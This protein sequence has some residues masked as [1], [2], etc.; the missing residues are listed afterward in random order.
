MINKYRKDFPLLKAID[1]KKSK[2]N[3]ALV[4]LDT[5]ATAQRPY[6]VLEAMEH[7]YST[8]NANPLRGLYSL[9]ERA[10]KAYEDARSTAANFI[11]AGDSRQ[12]IFTRNATESLNLVANTY[13][14]ANVNPGDEIVISIME[15]HSNILPW[16]FVCQTKGAT[17]KYMYIDKQTGK[18]PESEYQKITA[19]TKIVAITQV[20]NVLG[21]ENPIKEISKIAHENGAIIVVD[22]AQSAAHIKVDVQDMDAD[23]FAFSA[24]KLCGPM[25]IGCLYGKLDLL[26]KM[27]PFLRGGEMI[28]YVSQTSAT[29]AELPHKFEAGTVSAADAVGMSAAIKYIQSIGFEKIAEHDSKLACRLVEGLKKIPHVNIIGSQDG[30]KRCGIVTFTVEGVHPHDIATLLSDENIAIRAGHHCAQPLG[31]YLEVP[32]TARASLYFY[33]TEEEVDFFIQKVSMLRKWSG[34]KD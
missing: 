3:S 20:S 24:H 29:W 22:G 21:T 8:Q 33:N 12:I 15:H 5:A 18:I 6:A 2:D 31:E 11:N 34:Y 13:A 14:I 16:Q 10:T 26:E 17:L 28:E 4:Y 27:P 32:S 25:G 19:K 23:F 1:E 30:S 9:S 7:F